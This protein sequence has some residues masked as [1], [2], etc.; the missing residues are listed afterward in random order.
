MPFFG[1]ST[2]T[3]K[4][5]PSK[6]TPPMP[7]ILPIERAQAQVSLFLSTPGD[8]GAAAVA[9][10]CRKLDVKSLRLLEAWIPQG[11]ARMGQRCTKAREI[12]RG[13]LAEK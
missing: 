7:E 6:E 1:K 13:V 2:A 5:P 8:M 11:Q 10:A 12:V 4:P 3:I 9:E